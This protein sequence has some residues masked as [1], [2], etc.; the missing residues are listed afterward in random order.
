MF[1]S[2]I[3]PRLAAAL[4]LSFVASAPLPCTAL[5]S[6]APLTAAQR[7]SSADAVFIGTVLSV[8]EAKAGDTDRGY[9]PEWATIRPD[10]GWKGVPRS[11]IELPSGFGPDCLVSFKAGEQYLI[12]AD[13]GP[14]GKYATSWCAGSASIAERQGS[15]AVAILGA[16]TDT[17]PPQVTAQ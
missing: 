2:H 10:A 9:V 17:V 4:A 8:R 6:C 13:Q 5:C 12:Y 16:P 15:L 11:P 1:S 14:S 7:F 3:I